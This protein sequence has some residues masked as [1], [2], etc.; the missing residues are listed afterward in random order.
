[1]VICVRGMGGKG[2][3]FIWTNEHTQVVQQLKEAL[4]KAP[5]LCQPDYNGERPIIVTIDTSPIG[6]GW[7]INQEDE[8]QH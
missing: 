5:V 1:M 7:V 6:I 8:E 2:K 3:K 4:L